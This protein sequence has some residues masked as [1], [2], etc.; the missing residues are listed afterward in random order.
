MQSNGLQNIEGA[1]FRANSKY[2]LVLFDRLS[3]EQRE[4][5]NRSQQD[6]NLYG[7]LRPIIPAVKELK[8]V[9]HDT[10][11]LFFTLQQSS[12]LPAYIKNKFGDQY[13]T[14]IAKLVLD[15]ILEI[16]HNG[17]FVSGAEAYEAL[18]SGEPAASGQDAIAKLSLEALQYAQ[19]LRIDDAAQ[20]SNR[21]YFY[22]CVPPSPKRRRQFSQ[23]AAVSD[24]LGIE[25]LNYSLLRRNWSMHQSGQDRD[26]WFTWFSLCR[27]RT[28]HSDSGTYKLYVSPQC[29]KL[30]EVFRTTVEILS[31]TPTLSFKVGNS[32]HGVL[33]PDKFVAYFNDFESLSKTADRLQRELSGFPAHGV[34]FTASITDDGLLS[35]GVDPPQNLKT[36]LISLPESWRI[37]V[38]NRLAVA[39][40]AAR[41]SRQQTMEPWQYAVERLKLEG[42]DTTTWAPTNS[43][44]AI[45]AQE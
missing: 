24:Y 26:Y 3:A 2:Q 36:R 33:R 40:L 14:A 30:A 11:L 35:W 13:N 37:W 18:Y 12:R 7:V 42:V 28:A 22:N 32:I 43:W 21:L 4:V 44:R 9:C 17:E 29:D 10:A 15:E 16:A 31:I 20:V 23:Q 27:Q 34:P 45:E 8:A 19:K 1:T 41:R 6:N 39:L 25:D 5:L 38:T